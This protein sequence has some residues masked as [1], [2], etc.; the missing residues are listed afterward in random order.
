MMGKALAVLVTSLRLSE[1]SEIEKRR[2]E[3]YGLELP[4][5]IT[6]EDASGGF[7]ERVGFTKDISSSGVCLMC[8]SCIEQGAEVD[9]KIELPIVLE[10]TRG[11]HMSARGTVVRNESLSDP[12]EGYELGIMFDRSYP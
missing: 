12:H 6:W 1:V 8:E 9:L 10:G 7:G 2:W 5:H 11:S 4:V 3:R